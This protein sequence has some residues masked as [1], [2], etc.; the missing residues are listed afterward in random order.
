MKPCATC[1]YFWNGYKGSVC[2]I[3][4]KT[5]RE[6]NPYSG[7]MENW[8]SRRFHAEWMRSDK[9][10]CGPDRKLYKQTL[11]SKLAPYFYWS[12]FLGGIIFLSYIVY[13]EVIKNA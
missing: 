4:Q 12:I 8:V 10:E 3:H 13:V 6:L 7:E 5:E 1:K 11:S 9:G 2:C